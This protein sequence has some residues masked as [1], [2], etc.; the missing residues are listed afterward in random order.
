MPRHIF[1]DDD[2]VAHVIASTGG[3]GG[4]SSGGG[5]PEAPLDG[6]TY[7]RNNA[8]WK[9]VEAS[10]GIPEAPTDNKL[11]GRKNA[12]WAPVEASG[13]VPE[14][15]TDGQTYGR[16]NSAWT[17]VESSNTSY[18]DAEVATGDIWTDGKPIY[19]QIFTGRI[20]ASGAEIYEVILS[21]NI[22]SVINYNGWWRNGGNQ[23]YLI[24]VWLNEYT[25]SYLYF[26]FSSNRVIFTSCSE[27]NRPGTS[28]C[29][30]SIMVEYTKAT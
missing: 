16:R 4:G 6:K 17:P 27:N 28:N 2:G 22:D 21:E 10:G 30:Y 24:D 15:P 13:G 18:V 26:Q 3:V 20:T 29:A 14:A 8:I 9:P 19:R 25:Y 23:L 12:L 5:V 7:G 1:I 11:Y